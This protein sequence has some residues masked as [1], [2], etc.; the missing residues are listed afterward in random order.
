MLK[1]YFDKSGREEKKFLTLSGITAN[2]KAWKDIERTWHY[3]LDTHEPKATCMHMHQAVHLQ[4]EFDRA[5]GWDDT[6]AS[7]LVNWLLSYV[8]QFEQMY[9]SY[10]QFVC[11]VDMEA[12]R[13][14]ESETYLMDS[15][16]DICNETCVEGVMAWYISH[17]KSDLDYEASYYFDAGEPFEPLFKAK[18][19]R[20]KRKDEAIGRYGLWSHIKHVGAVPMHESPG[21]QIADMLAWG[22]NREKNPV[23]G[24]PIPKEYEHIALAMTRLAPSFSKL[25]DE[26]ELRQRYRPLVFK[27]FERF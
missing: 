17:Y 22:I 23:A 25:W 20:E 16:V 2:D 18:W 21:I 3:M 10:C 15:P 5:K 24:S 1:S 11:T 19:E 14:L 6:K 13:K 26:S 27:P 9:D 7:G 8:T 4:K 12:Y